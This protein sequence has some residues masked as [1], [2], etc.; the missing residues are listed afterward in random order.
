MGILPKYL[1]GVND[2]MSQVK[3]D[4]SKTSEIFSTLQ[5]A[6]N[7]CESVSDPSKDENTT[8][9]GNK[10][11]HSAIDNLMKMNQSVTKAIETASKNI[12]NVGDAFEQADQAIGNDISRN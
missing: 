9:S 4:T 12:Q 6:I 3:S 11:A 7:E 10:D 8:V 2:E 5:S 1:R